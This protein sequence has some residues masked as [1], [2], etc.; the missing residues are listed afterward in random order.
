MGKWLP[1][2]STFAL[3][4]IGATVSC[5]E[6]ADGSRTDHTGCR[7]ASYLAPKSHHAL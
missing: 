4:N 7:M 1:F 6:A 2:L 3:E 5:A